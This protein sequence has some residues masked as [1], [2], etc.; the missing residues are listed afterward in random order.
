MPQ[1]RLGRFFNSIAKPQ[2]LTAW[3]ITMEFYRQRHGVQPDTVFT[4]DL[5]EK[6]QQLRMFR[7]E[8]RA[9]AT[10][11]VPALCGM[12]IAAQEEIWRRTVSITRSSVSRNLIGL[13]YVDNRLWISERRFEQMPGVRLFLNSRFYGGDIVLED[14]PAFDFVGFSLDLQNRRIFSTI[15]C[16]NLETCPALTRHPRNQCSSAECWQEPAPSKNVL[17][18]DGKLCR[19]SESCGTPPRSAVFQFIPLPSRH[20]FGIYLEA[21][22]A[23]HRAKGICSKLHVVH[24]MP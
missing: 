20:S 24:S 11:E 7:G 22:A 9:R 19:T 1:P 18:L 8:R 15:E 14:E 4:I 10:R 6:T 17:I 21:F 13:R 5:K 12:V 3:R 23:L 16:A 2:F